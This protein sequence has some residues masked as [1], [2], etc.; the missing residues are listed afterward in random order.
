MYHKLALTRIRH[1]FILF[2]VV[3]WLLYDCK[4]TSSVSAVHIFYFVTEVLI[5]TVLDLINFL[6]TVVISHIAIV[7]CGLCSPGKRVD[8][9][10]LKFDA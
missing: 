6:I 4:L 9:G 8:A 1:S 2:L 10:F 3:S 5:S 7:M